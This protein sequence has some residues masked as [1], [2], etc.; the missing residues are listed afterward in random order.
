MGQMLRQQF[1]RVVAISGEAA[2]RPL[3]VN[4]RISAKHARSILLRRGKSWARLWWKMEEI[5]GAREHYIDQ[6]PVASARRILRHQEEHEERRDIVQK[7]RMADLVVVEGDGNLVLKPHVGRYLHFLLAIIEL[8]VELD[9][10]VHYVNSIVSDCSLTGRNEELARRCAGTLRKC[11]SIALRDPESTR[12]FGEIAPDLEPALIPDTLFSWYPDVNAAVDAV[13]ARGD[14]ILPHW[15]ET[16][17]RFGALRFD[18]PYICVSGGS[19]AS[20]NPGESA[21]RYVSLVNRLK[22]LG[23]PVYLVPTCRGDITHPSWRR[24]AERPAST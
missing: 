20:W 19:R 8:A 17:D 22:S 24:W 23:Y 15:S 10:P 16:V 6:D 13:P 9:T 14:F 7:V 2:E 18:E 21:D 12:V 5:L 11:T 1:G 4:A 3:P